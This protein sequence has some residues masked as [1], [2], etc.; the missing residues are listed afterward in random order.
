ML[1]FV[2]RNTPFGFDQLVRRMLETKTPITA[3]MH[4]GTWIDIGRIEDLRR[5]QETAAAQLIGPGHDA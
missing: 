5:A 4:P 1:E 3:Y 2:P